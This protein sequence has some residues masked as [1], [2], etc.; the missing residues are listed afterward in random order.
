MLYICPIAKECPPE[1]MKSYPTC[2]A[3][4]P[5]ISSKKPADDGC[6]EC[7]LC[8][9][10]QPHQCTK[11]VEEGC[12]CIHCGTKADLITGNTRDRQCGITDR[13]IK[14]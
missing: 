1:K 6:P 12:F 5:H 3:R 11:I 13:G 8:T 9:E 10:Y 7:V 4:I 14:Y 2:F